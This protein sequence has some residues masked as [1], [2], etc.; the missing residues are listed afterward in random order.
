LNPY[1]TVQSGY[2][3]AEGV[4][5][6]TVTATDGAGNVGSASVTY[7]VD[8]TAPVVA[9]TAPANGAYYTTANV[10]AKDFAVT[11]LNP[12]TTVQ[13]GYS[14][15]EGVQTYTVTATDGAG[16][17]G[18]ASVTYTVDNVAPVVTITAPVAGAYYRQ[19]QVVLADWTATDALSGIA[20]LSGTVPSGSPIPTGTVGAN[21]FTV[22]ATDKAGNTTTKTV[23]YNVWSYNFIGFLPPVDNPS[24]VNVGKAG[25]TFPIKWQL[26]DY[27]GNFISDLSLVKLTYRQ[28]AT[29]TSSPQDT[30][31]D[32]SGASGLRYD[33][34]SNQYIFNWQTSS[35]FTNKSYEFIL[36]LNDGTVHNALFKFT[37]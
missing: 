8:N 30:I 12:Y 5:T 28:I 18:S 35:T 25:R 7:T 9:I 36:T 4:Q 13:S 11:E 22:T 23:T 2:S 16:N 14:T 15:A 33:S 37:K 34:T 1:T 31:P 32:T 20:S 21:T 26:K 24:V 27:Q 17:V 10:P 19:T 3:T 29:D 6:Y